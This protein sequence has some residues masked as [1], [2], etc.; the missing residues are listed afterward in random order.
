MSNDVD[1]NKLIHQLVDSSGDAKDLAWE[2]SAKSMAP[3]EGVAIVPLAVIQRYAFALRQH[4][5]SWLLLAL[6]KSVWGWYPRKLSKVADKC[7]LSAFLFGDHYHS[8]WSLYSK[9]IIY[10]IWVN[11]V[12]FA[13]LL[14]CL[15]FDSLTAMRLLPSR[16]ISK[17]HEILSN[18]DGLRFYN[19][20][21]EFN[22][23]DCQIKMRRV[24]S[25]CLPYFF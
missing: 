7:P 3:K 25:F 2:R 20:K 16:S 18:S 15:R 1:N 12:H 19:T 22:C 11:P 24:T 6:K 23:A 21:I 13:H 8:S 10:Q 4:S 5:S 14:E 9:I 17:T